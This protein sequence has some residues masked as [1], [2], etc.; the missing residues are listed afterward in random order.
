MP[1]DIGAG[2]TDKQ[3]SILIG[4]QDGRIRSYA[5]LTDN[6]FEPLE[7]TASP[8]NRICVVGGYGLADEGLLQAFTARVGK[9]GEQKRAPWV[10]AQL[11]G[12]IDRISELHPDSIGRGSYFAALDRHGPIRLPADFPEPPTVQE[13]TAQREPALAEAGN[14]FVGSIV[15]PR[16]GA[17]DSI[18]NSDGGVGAQFGQI[19]VLSMSIVNPTTTGGGGTIANPENSVD[20]DLT[21]FTTLKVTGSTIPTGGS[22]LLTLSGPPG[23]A[24]RY[25]S[26]VLKVAAAV[27]TNS[28]TSPSSLGSCVYSL[29]GGNSSAGAIFSLVGTTAA[30][31]IYSVTLP[32]GQNLSQVQ[33]QFDATVASNAGPGTVE[34]DVYSAWIEATS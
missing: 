8:G 5:F 13:V 1:K 11:R 18:G 20:G 22:A 34:V 24:Q 12:L 4:V 30:F 10:A 32:A 14:F 19:T 33:V 31:A 6:N 16:A 2:A 3:D 17:P 28:Y 21:T 15:T 25:Q 9:D 27:P 29:D 26:A 7:T 23:L